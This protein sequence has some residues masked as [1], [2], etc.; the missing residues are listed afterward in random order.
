MK[1]Q[2]KISVII[3]CYNS[4]EWIEEC[5]LS[6]ANQTYT[7]IEI[8][9]VDN[10]STDTTLDIVNTIKENYDNITVSSAPNI[11]PYC[12]DEAREVGFSLA[13]GDYYLTICSDD[14]LDTNF[15][16]NYI[17]V[18]NNTPED[19]LAF[20]SPIKGVRVDDNCPYFDPHQA[21]VYKDIKEFKEKCLVHCP[22]N[23]PTV[24]FHESLYKRGL[25]KTDPDTYSGAADYDLYCSLADAGVFIYPIP[26]WVGYY[27]RWHENQATW[28]I[29]NSGVNYDTLIRN[30]WRGKWTS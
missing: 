13:T 16:S 6:V 19:T 15:I 5:L 22:V 14:Y 1:D 3:P 30:H 27:Y 10:E 8:I 24:L 17:I 21:H 9:V 26:Q 12:W 20:Q 25:L 29:R 7:N 18:I 28:G 4:E 2:P 11:Y 23:T